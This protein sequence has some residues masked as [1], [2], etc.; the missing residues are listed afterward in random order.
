M[1]KNQE[2]SELSCCCKVPFIHQPNPRIFECSKCHK[3]YGKVSIPIDQESVTRE[4]PMGVSQWAEHGR[5][6]GYWG[7]FRTEVLN[8]AIEVL[9]KIE[10]EPLFSSGKKLNPGYVLRFAQDQLFRLFSNPRDNVQP[11]AFK[12]EN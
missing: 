8:E 2:T 3:E 9:E 7:Y 10:S 12:A 5:K 1:S 6:Y 11:S 4:S